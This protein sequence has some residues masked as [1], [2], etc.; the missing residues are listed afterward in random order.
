MA[1][2]NTTN[3]K[4]LGW[5]DRD[6]ARLMYREES[7]KI[8]LKNRLAREIGGKITVCDW[9]E[10]TTFGSSC[11]KV[12]K[13]ERS[14][15]FHCTENNDFCSCTIAKGLDGDVFETHLSPEFPWILG[16]QYILQM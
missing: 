12:R 16:C 1:K 14:P 2:I 7:R 11:R 13:T 15:G 5:P 10:G 4:H 6:V 9:G 8:G 3:F